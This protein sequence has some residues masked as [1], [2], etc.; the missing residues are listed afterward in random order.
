[1]HILVSNDDGILAPGIGLLAEACRSVGHVTVVAPDREQSGTSHSLTLHRPLRAALRPD[2]AYQVDGTPTDCVLL[3]VN[4]LL[5]ERPSF[6]FSGVNHGPNMGEDVLYSGTVAVAMEAVTLGIPGVAISFAGHDPEM[7]ATYGP[8]L[9]RLVQQVVAVPDISR[10]Y[11]PE[12]ESARRARLGGEGDD[13]DPTR[14]PVFFGVADPDEGPMGPR[15]VL[16]RRRDDYLDRGRRLRPWRGGGGVRFRHAAAHGPHALPTDR[17]GSGMAAGAVGAG[18][19]YGGYRA[20]LVSELQAKGI[21]DL[22]VLRAVSQVPRH[23]FVPA[24]VRHRAYEDSALPIGGGQ[25]ISQPWVQARYLEVL[26][27]TGREKVLEVGTGSGYQT[28]LLALLADTV[29]SIERI[30]SLAS[31][32][33]AALEGAGIR[34]VTVLVGDGTLGWRPFAPYDAILVAAASPT[35]PAPLVEQLAPGGRLVIPIGDRESQV[36]QLL[37][38]EGDRIVTTSLGDVRFVPLL[39]EFGFRPSTS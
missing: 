32:A 30:Q 15:D 25:T 37:R 28:A 1:M 11:H 34:N 17:N 31:E 21:R 18:D 38:K 16:G 6:V 2:G 23:Q 33:R 29:F 9:K 20:R 8:L 35:V 26:E 36:L 19:S 39:G 24:S 10:R 27:L 3:A 12:R 7:L 4:A 22:A 13:G 5:P 14:Q